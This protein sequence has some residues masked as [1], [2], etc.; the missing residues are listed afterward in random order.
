MIRFRTP[1]LTVPLEG[2]GDLRLTL[3]SGPGMQTSPS[4]RPSVLAEQE[5]S[6]SRVNDLGGR[7]PLRGKIALGSLRTGGGTGNQLMQTRE[8]KYSLMLASASCE[9]RKQPLVANEEVQCWPQCGRKTGVG[10]Q[11]GSPRA[12]QQELL[13]ALISGLL[14]DPLGL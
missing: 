8:R 6:L 9:P 10:L 14:P 3:S 5:P 7:R 11:P 4:A 1:Y 13:A 12:R 2:S